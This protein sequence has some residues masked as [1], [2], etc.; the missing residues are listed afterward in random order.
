MGAYNP[1]DDNLR[2]QHDR[3]QPR[4]PYSSQHILDFLHSLHALFISSLLYPQ[5]I[6]IP[7]YFDDFSCNTFP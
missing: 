6:F 4:R 1:P 3:R 5:F 2:R 7:G